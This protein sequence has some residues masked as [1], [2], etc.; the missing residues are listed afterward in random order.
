V[1]LA[2]AGTSD[3]S[4]QRDLHMMAT[5]LSAATGLR[6]EL[7]FAATGTPRVPDA[8]ARCGGGARDGW[9]WR[10]TCCRRACLPTGCGPAAPTW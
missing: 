4:A 3:P 10:H 8:V 6:V 2:A 5:W 7:A 1:I 9:W